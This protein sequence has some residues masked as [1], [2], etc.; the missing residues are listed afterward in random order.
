M[1]ARNTALW[2]S[3]KPTGISD[4]SDWAAVF[5]GKAKFRVFHHQDWVAWVKQHDE[6]KQWQDWLEWVSGRYGFEG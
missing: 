1:D 3:L 5:K 4:A 6:S 2:Q